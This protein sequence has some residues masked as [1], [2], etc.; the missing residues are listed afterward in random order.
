MIEASSCVGGP[1]ESVLSYLRKERFLN[2]WS[3]R[4]LDRR[5]MVGS[6]G[7]G[8]GWR[9]VAPVI[10]WDILPM[11]EGKQGRH[12]FTPFPKPAKCSQL[13]LARKSAGKS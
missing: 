12:S 9:L 4:G 11:L 3:L 7:A 2:D 1:T 6:D 5:I 10:A 13:S 8:K